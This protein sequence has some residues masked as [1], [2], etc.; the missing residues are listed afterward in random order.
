VLAL[1][2]ITR[3]IF[4]FDLIF[5]LFTGWWLSTDGRAHALI[6]EYQWEQK[7]IDAGFR[8]VL[9]TDGHCPE[10]KTVRIIAAFPQS[11]T[12]ETARKGAVQ[13]RVKEVVYKR[14]GDCEI[15]A[16]VYCLVG[17]DSRKAL[18]IGQI[19]SRIV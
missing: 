18:P 13:C 9:W 1:V 6:D 19:A 3:N 4:I 12:E 8:D 17:P 2:E 14:S 16:D 11:D 15:L 10:S 5:G 7:M